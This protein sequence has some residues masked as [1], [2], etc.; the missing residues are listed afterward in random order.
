[1]GDFDQTRDKFR[2]ILGVIEI[3]F[4]QVDHYT[5]KSKIKN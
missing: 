1:M 2:F 5:F 3:E 4:L